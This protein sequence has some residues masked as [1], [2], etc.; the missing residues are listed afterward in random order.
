MSEVVV[1]GGGGGFIGGHL[2]GRL[3]E[4]GL[5]VRVADIKPVHEW[6]QLH[7]EAENLELDLSHAEDC[8]RAVE[9]VSQV[10][11]LAADSSPASLRLLKPARVSSSESI[12]SLSARLATRLRHSTEFLGGTWATNVGT[13]RNTPRIAPRCPHDPTIGV[14]PAGASRHIQGET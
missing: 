5:E 2:V 4:R 11:N 6:H 9:G 7:D 1:V 3:L 14:T 12:V 10:Y 8:A 13:L